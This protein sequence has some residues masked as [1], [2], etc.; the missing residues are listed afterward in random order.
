MNIR[1]DVEVPVLNYRIFCYNAFVT[2]RKNKRLKGTFILFE[3][4]MNENEVC[5]RKTHKVHRRGTAHEA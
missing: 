1:I 4:F 3:I 5:F 2:M